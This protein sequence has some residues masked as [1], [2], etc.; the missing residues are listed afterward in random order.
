[1][2]ERMCVSQRNEEWSKKRHAWLVVKIYHVINT[3]CTESLLSRKRT[4]VFTYRWIHRGDVEICMYLYARRKR[5]YST[6]PSQLKQ[7][8]ASASQGNCL[9]H[10]ATAIDNIHS[11][12]Y[13]AQGPFLDTG[14]YGADLK[15]CVRLSDV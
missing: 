4:F 12:Q 10:T 3:V 14:T 2:K 13:V 7:T 5:R 15:S 8:G 9:S 1:M 11:S 6:H